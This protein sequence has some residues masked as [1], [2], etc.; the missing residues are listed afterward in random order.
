M[1]NTKTIEQGSGVQPELKRLPI[2]IALVIGAFFSI[3]N[4]TLLNV[5]FHRLSLDLEVP[6]TTIQWLSTVYMLIVGILVPISALLVG[7]FTTRQ[8]FIGALCLFTIGTFVCGI[9]F[10]FPQLLIGRMIQAVGAGF[11]ATSHDE[12]DLV[13]IS[14]GKSRRR[15]GKYRSRH[16]VRPGDWANARRYNSR[17]DEL[18]MAVFLSAAIYGAYR[19]CSPSSS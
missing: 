16:Y 12:H 7:W 3:L 10:G 13:P 17:C 1:Q 5:A 2:L 4:E 15:H 14:A 8:M 9:A 19:Y 18:A 6:Y 11:N